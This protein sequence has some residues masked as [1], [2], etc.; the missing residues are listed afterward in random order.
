VP[1]SIFM[2][3]WTPSSLTSGPSRLPRTHRGINRFR[4]WGS[5][6]VGRASRSPLCFS[7]L[8][9]PAAKAEH[10]LISVP[11]AS[12]ECA[13]SSAAVTSSTPNR[14]ASLKD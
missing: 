10:P 6:E 12:V 14:F 3:E 5:G 8:A 9:H 11:E 13:G 2:C 7:L 1:V 4:G